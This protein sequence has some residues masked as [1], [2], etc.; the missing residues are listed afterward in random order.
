MSFAS[1]LVAGRTGVC[2]Q[3]RGAGFTLEQNSPNCVG[4]RKRPLHTIIPGMVLRGGRLYLSYGLIGGHM[5]PQG[6]IQLICNILDFGMTPQEA[7]EAPRFFHL[8]NGQLGLEWPI[9]PEVRAQ[10][11]DR[12]HLLSPPGGLYGGGQLIMRHPDTGV[13]SAGS[14][15]RKD[16]C[17]LAY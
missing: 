11:A 3:N 15:P 1:G 4:P 5:Q 12:G 14:D 8:E 7:L 2:L 10:L 9:S 17:A 6:H 13:L 16:G